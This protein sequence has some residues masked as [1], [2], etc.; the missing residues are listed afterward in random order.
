[1]RLIGMDIALASFSR[2]HLL[3]SRIRP[4][5]DEARA[6]HFAASLYIDV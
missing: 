6:I 2:R 3:A 4:P 5:A 1:M